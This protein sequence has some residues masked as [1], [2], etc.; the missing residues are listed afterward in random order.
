MNGSTVK[1]NVAFFEKE[2][3]VDEEKVKQCLKAACILED[4]MAMPDGLNTLIGAQG[5]A[6]SGGQ[7]QRIALARA[8]Y[9][10]F[11]LLIMDEATA[12]LDSDTEKAVMD[13]I[14]QLRGKKTLLMVTH[15][16]FVSEQCDIVY[17]VKEGK[18]MREK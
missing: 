11:E 5:I 6:I 10:D 17:R 13:S 12:A 16:D 9:K 4:V 15:H 2:A 18:I 3:A 7:R 8:L 14:N 1:E